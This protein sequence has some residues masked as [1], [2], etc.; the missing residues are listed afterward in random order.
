M[1]VVNFGGDCLYY[2]NLNISL[3]KEQ[4]NYINSLEF[5]P[6]TIY[7]NRVSKDFFILNSP[8]MESIKE[9]FDNQIKFYTQE[10]WGINN[11]FK[12]LNSWATINEP[13]AYH[14]KHHHPNSI[15]ALSYYIQADGGEIYFQKIRTSIQN[16]HLFDYNI[17]KPNE[18]NCNTQQF[19]VTSGDIC[20]FPS[21][22]EHGTRKNT[23]NKSRVMIAANYFVKG[24]IG[25]NER[26][27]YLD[28]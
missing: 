27:T 8:I 20:I 9:L 12:L 18:Y 14:A 17:I 10:L 11:K 22:I 25:S 23:S 7:G 24:E 2:N 3:N 5:K 6:K 21:H 1:K 19:S 16:G 26:L 4:V 28:I 13:G 15:L